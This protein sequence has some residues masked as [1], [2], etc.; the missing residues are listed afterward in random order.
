M[1]KVTDGSEQGRMSAQIAVGF[2]GNSVEYRVN[3]ES[4]MQLSDAWA[5]GRVLH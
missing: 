5:Y 3:F 4:Q 2:T 1:F